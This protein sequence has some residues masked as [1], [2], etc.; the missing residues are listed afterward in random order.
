ME[1]R[2]DTY[3]HLIIGAGMCGLSLARFLA[4]KGESVLLLEKSKGLG[5][6]VATRRTPLAL[7]DHGAQFYK[8]RSTESVPWNQRWEQ[9]NLVRDWFI[10][11][12]FH[13]RISPNGMTGL[14]KDLAEDLPV[15][16]EKTAAL[17]RFDEEQGELNLLCREGDIFNAKHVHL[18]C[19]L[20]QALDILD[21][22]AFS[23][24]PKLR[25]IHYAKALVALVVMD[26]PLDF[27]Y[28][29]APSDPIFSI[30]HQGRKHGQAASALTLVA[31]PEW[32]EEHWERDDALDLMVGHLESILGTQAA[33]PARAIFR[34][35]KKWRYA[36]PLNH[37]TEKFY[38]VPDYPIFLAGDAFGGASI[39][40]A[41]RS[42]AA[43]AQE[44]TGETFD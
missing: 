11:D 18:T 36:Q 30:S 7:F 40:G 13:Y 5:G 41:L 19:P 43:L 2:H 21:S 6:R 37:F 26:G 17:I 27:D 3:N 39:K 23:F 16:K 10:A 44:L 33:Q 29:E 1:N 32:S 15:K 31:S 28:I 38:Q 24:E 25:D 12:D 14:A 9:K 8:M 35:L 20:P 34:Q 42:A 4:A 22:S